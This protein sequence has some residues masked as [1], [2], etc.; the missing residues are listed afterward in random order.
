[1]AVQHICAARD[2]LEVFALRQPP[3]DVLT[4][5]KKFLGFVGRTICLSSTGHGTGHGH[6][7]ELAMYSCLSQAA[8]T[9]HTQVVSAGASR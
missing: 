8:A 6:W 2:D 5:R 7:S 9:H 4:L 1:M 3:P